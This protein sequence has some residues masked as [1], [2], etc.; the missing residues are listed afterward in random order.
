[1]LYVPRGVGESL[2]ERHFKS[3]LKH[4]KWFLCQRESNLILKR[5]DYY[6]NNRYKFI[7]FSN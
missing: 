4:V 2:P 1:M 7:L 3:T 5:K 6:Q